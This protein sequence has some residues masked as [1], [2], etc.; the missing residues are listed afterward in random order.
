[1][2]IYAD[3]L[4]CTMSIS[5]WMEYEQRKHLYAFL[6]IKKKHTILQSCVFFVIFCTGIVSI[7]WNEKGG[8]EEDKWRLIC[9][10]FCRTQ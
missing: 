6:Y 5:F 3:D 9:F 10:L 4:R 7:Q 1:M 8:S 2:I